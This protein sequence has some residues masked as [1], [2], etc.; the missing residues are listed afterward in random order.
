MDAL[1][2]EVV[3]D[4]LG[5]H[6]VDHSKAYCLTILLLN[7]GRWGLAWAESWHFG[8]LAQMLQLVSDLLFDIFTGEGDV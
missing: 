7:D 8:G 6:L 5:G 1:L 2:L 4:L 3:A